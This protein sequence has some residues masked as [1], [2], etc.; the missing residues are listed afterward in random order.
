MNQQIA[1]HLT[2]CFLG[3]YKDYVDLTMIMTAI[4]LDC[5]LMTMTI[6]VCDNEE[7]RVKKDWP[8]LWI[9]CPGLHQQNIA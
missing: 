9:E 8:A 5:D 7:T 3:L 4:Y 1:Q 2:K 6:N